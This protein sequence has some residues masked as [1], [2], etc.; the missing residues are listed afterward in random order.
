MAHPGQAQFHFDIEHPASNIPLYFW[1]TEFGN[2]PSNILRMAVQPGTMCVLSGEGA[3]QTLPPDAILLA[4]AP[5]SKITLFNLGPAGLD[6]GTEHFSD[7]EVEATQLDHLQ[8]EQ[9]G[10]LFLH[11]FSHSIPNYPWV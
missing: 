9:V 8:I 7:G 2:S 4:T 6:I 11:I 3:R 5:T 10:S 1:P